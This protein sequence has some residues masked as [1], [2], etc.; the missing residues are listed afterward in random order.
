MCALVIAY[1]HGSLQFRSHSTPEKESLL[2]QSPSELK[3]KNDQ[4]E[5][6]D[7]N[8][9]NVVNTS[10]IKY[11]SG[12]L[13]S[14]DLYALPNKQRDDA[15]KVCEIASDDGDDDDHCDNLSNEDSIEEK[16]S[17]KDLPFGWEKHEDNDGP[18]YWHIKSGTIQR[19][20]PL[21]PKYVSEFECE[22]NPTHDVIRNEPFVR[23]QPQPQEQQHQQQTNKVAKNDSAEDTN[24][25]QV[26]G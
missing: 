9:K 11:I 26:S 17:N 25:T 12:T 24:R 13:N 18:Y 16:D 19:E 21:W 8:T 15:A 4:P 20:P 7:S 23:L 2:S 14:N 5:K 1:R 10:N 6:E 3:R 22:N